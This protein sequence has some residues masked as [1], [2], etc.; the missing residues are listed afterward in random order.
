MSKNKWSTKTEFLKCLDDKEFFFHISVPRSATNYFVTLFE[1]LTGRPRFDVHGDWQP[2][3]CYLSEEQKNLKPIFYGTHECFW[4]PNNPQHAK[5]SIGN[6]EFFTRVDKNRKHIVQIRDP[7]EVF[8]SMG[9]VD[10]HGGI[11]NYNTFAE[12]WFPDF[13][14]GKR[15][16]GNKFAI[17]YEDYIDNRED[18]IYE[19][20]EFLGMNYSRED[21]NTM[22]SDLGDKEKYLKSVS[23][24]YNQSDKDK[25]I[26]NAHTLSKKYSE[27]RETFKRN[28]TELYEYISVKNLKDYYVSR[29]KK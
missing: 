24:K 18:L 26:Q 28:N 6:E 9:H 14:V 17:L 23:K 25:H 10:M 27:D 15:R 4:G 16:Y 20:S 12:K 7:L 21:V 1:I 22:I 3:T 2:V 13:E 8:Y 11:H 29:S 19:L 5:F